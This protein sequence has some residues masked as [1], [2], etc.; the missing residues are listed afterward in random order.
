MNISS[1]LLHV[2]K[3]DPIITHHCEQKANKL[4]KE[5]MFC[6]PSEHNMQLLKLMEFRRI[7]EERDDDG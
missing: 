1:L 3:L 7:E 2:F 4:F 5:D 6:L